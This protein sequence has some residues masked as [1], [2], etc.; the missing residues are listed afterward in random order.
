[1]YRLR[2]KS[3]ELY[4][5]YTNTDGQDNSKWNFLIGI[6]SR[7]PC[8]L[9]LQ[10]EQSFRELE[11]CLRSSSA[12]WATTMPT[13]M[14]PTIT[15]RRRKHFLSQQ[16]TGTSFLMVD[17]LVEY[18]PCFER[19][20]DFKYGFFLHSASPTGRS[21]FFRTVRGCPHPYSVQGPTCDEPC[22]L[23]YGYRA[24]CC[25]GNSNI[26]TRLESKEVCLCN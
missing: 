8:I 23:Q 16:Y 5:S 9:I 18:G 7:Q 21:S 15:T 3:N 14:T 10:C 17:I 26:D 11:R 1:M 13:I 19:L 24:K 25:G 20:G 2:P 4:R 22:N 6:V 12:V